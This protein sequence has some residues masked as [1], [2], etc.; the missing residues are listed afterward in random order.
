MLVVAVL[1]KLDVALVDGIVD[2]LELDILEV[3]KELEE[4]ILVEEE[5]PADE[6]VVLDRV[7]V[8]VVAV[9]DTER[10]IVDDEEVLSRLVD[11]TLLC[12]AVEVDTELDKLP[13]SSEVTKPPTT[14]PSVE[15]D[16]ED[17]AD[18][19]IVLV[20]VV[21]NTL[22]D[23][24]V[25]ALVVELDEEEE[26]VVTI[27]VL[28]EVEKDVPDVMVVEPLVYVPMRTARLTVVVPPPSIWP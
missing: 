11:D 10:V 22:V 3:L 5:P 20:L 4:S 19:E 16:V 21:L 28:L 7:Y 15:V 8:V 13:P 23:E 14:P 9:E 6:L 12:V 27:K 17:D 1:V 24:A 18:P 25:E 2:E 26:T